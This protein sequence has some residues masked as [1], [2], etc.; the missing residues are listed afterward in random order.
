MSQPRYSDPNLALRQAETFEA[1]GRF[2]QAAGIYRD[3]LELFPSHPDL[4]NSA[5]LVEKRLGRFAEAETLLRRALRAA[6]SR[7]DLLNNLA[8]V[9]RALAK[10]EEAEK[11]LRRAIALNPKYTEAHYNLALTFEQAGRFAEALEAHA[12]ALSCNPAYVPALVRTGA[13]LLSGGGPGEALAPLDRAV[14]LNTGSFDGHYTRGCALAALGKFEDALAAFRQAE[15]IAPNRFEL[16]LAIAN[17]LRDSGRHDE[18]VDAYGRALDLEP[19]RADLHTQFACLAHEQGR[20]DAYATFAATRKRKPG[21]PDLLLAE[22]RLRFRGGEMEIAEQLMRDA[23]AVSPDRGDVAGFLGT[24]LAETGKFDETDLWFERAIANEPESAF[25]RHQFGFALLKRGELGRA[26]NQFE[27]SLARDRFDQLALAGYS[28]LLR[29]RSDARYAEL[30]DIGRYVR[31]YEISPAGIS[32]DALASELRGL[33][34]TMRAPLNQTLRNGTQTLGDLFARPSPSLAALRRAIGE[35]I[36]DYIA[37]LPDDA[38]NPVCARKTRQ[39]AF[40]GS[41]SCLLHPSGYHANHVHPQGWIS[42]ALYFDLPRAVTNAEFR[43]GWFKLGQSNL[44]LGESD[45]AERFIRPERGMLVLFPSFYWHGTVPF[46]G[47]DSRL[48]VAF[49]VVPA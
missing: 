29:A 2:D 15:E 38:A 46:S 10:L 18:A 16:R 22:A 9:Q 36:V 37:A 25:H 49:D 24:V 11:N 48:T 28:L 4:L 6:A 7:A 3:L 34:H 8:N 31:T 17:A 13:L 12:A 27:A 35:K 47:N 20:P 33:H 32:V 26:R 41:W 44:A 5:A 40:A 19:S 30:V 42:S 39:F 14:A 45:V 23:A 1:A 43:E 21:D